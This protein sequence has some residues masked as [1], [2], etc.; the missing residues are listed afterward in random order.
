[1]TRTVSE[2]P[3]AKDKP[4]SVQEVEILILPDKNLKTAL[5][6]DITPKVKSQLSTINPDNVEKQREYIHHVLKEVEGK[7]ILASESALSERLRD[8]RDVALEAFVRSFEVVPALGSDL[9]KFCRE[10]LPEPSEKKPK[11]KSKALITAIQKLSSVGQ[12]NV[13]KTI[14]S[15]S[16][17]APT[18]R[19]AAERITKQFP[20]G[21]GAESSSAATKGIKIADVASPGTQIDYA[22][23]EKQFLQSNSNDKNTIISRLGQ[24]L[25][26]LDKSSDQSQDEKSSA[27]QTITR[28]IVQ[29]LNASEATENKIRQL[30]LIIEEASKNPDSPLS[31]IALDQLKDLT[32]TGYLGVL[33]RFK[34]APKGTFT[35]RQRMSFTEDLLKLFS[36]KF[37]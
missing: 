32:Q 13:Q 21:S 9:V 29:E 33:G 15:I 28:L 14:D 3:P 16:S 8:L 30:A 36:D 19:N 34:A 26:A 37:N 12:K 1:M 22:A 4:D 5:P 25:L 18:E 31:I 2:R 24:R 20:K 6:K 23:L 27:L 11:V 7:L 35:K 10:Y 17:R